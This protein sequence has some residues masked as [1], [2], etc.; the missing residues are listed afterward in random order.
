MLSY[1]GCD[2]SQVQRYLTAKSV[3]EGRQSLMMSA[4]LKIP[5]QALVLLTGVLV[6]VF[7]LFNQPP[8]LFN[9]EH[10]EKIARSARAGEYQRSRGEFAA[11]FEARRDGRRGARRRPS[12]GADQQ[13]RASFRATDARGQRRPRA[14]AAQLVR[15]VTGDERYKDAPAT[16][17]RRTSTTCSRR[18]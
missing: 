9:P 13:A 12:D 3:D 15:E 18:S 7:Y 16:R 1:F 8:M 10:A 17:R 6:F 14:R 2:Q 11:A 5:L 4:Y